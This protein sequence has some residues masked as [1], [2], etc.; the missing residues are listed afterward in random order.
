M[1]TETEQVNVQLPD[2]PNPK[3]LE[4]QFKQLRYMEDSL[5]RENCFVPPVCHLSSLL[6][7]GKLTGRSIG[8]LGSGGPDLVLRSGMMCVAIRLLSFELGCWDH[9]A[10]GDGGSC[11][12]L[13]GLRK[14][15]RGFVRVYG[16]YSGSLFGI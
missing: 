12:T 13:T 9:R 8:M 5:F 10:D 16:T 14:S 15:L 1:V 7:L 6:G 3:N 4:E 11:R 2:C